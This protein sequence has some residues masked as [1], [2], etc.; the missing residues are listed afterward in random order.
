M[1]K[2]AGSLQTAFIED[3]KKKNVASSLK[4]LRIY[5]LRHMADPDQNN[6]T[7]GEDSMSPDV[8][9]STDIPTE[10]SGQA[11]GGDAAFNISQFL[12][13]VSYPAAKE[14]LID[15]ATDLGAEDVVIEMLE[16]LPD[17]TYNTPADVRQALNEGSNP[18]T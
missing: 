11:G 1:S 7:E 6:Q 18:V 3:L 2:P 4:I 15:Y 9:M 14:D 12:E 10:E 5:L 16:Q 8:K 17:T 13:R